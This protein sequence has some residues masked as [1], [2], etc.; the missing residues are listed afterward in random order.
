M[1]RIIPFSKPDITDVEINEV[2][3]T[4]KSGWITTGKKVKVFEEKISEYCGN[5]KT[6][7]LNSATARIRI[8]IKNFRNRKRR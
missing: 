8:N 1:Q 2:I 4:L 5:E 7:C 3:D 6:I